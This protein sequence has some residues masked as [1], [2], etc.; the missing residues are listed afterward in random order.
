MASF[1]VSDVPLSDVSMLAGVGYVGD[2]TGEGFVATSSWQFGSVSLKDGMAKEKVI[3]NR[4]PHTG[5]GA[6]LAPPMTD[7]TE[8]SDM[9]AAGTGTLIPPSACNC[10]VLIGECTYSSTEGF[11]GSDTKKES[12]HRTG[13][14]GLGHLGNVEN[15]REKL[16]KYGNPK[17]VSTYAPKSLNAKMHEDNV[18]F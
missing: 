8:E 4:G 13:S 18:F 16:R 7:G 12:Y 3:T 5:V 2:G 1:M 11:P 17:T 9:R 6:P 10:T 14:M 15:F